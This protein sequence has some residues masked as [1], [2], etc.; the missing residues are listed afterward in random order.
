M[1]VKGAPES[2]LVYPDDIGIDIYLGIYK[3]ELSL[4]WFLHDVIAHARKVD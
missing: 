3:W 4:I 2:L 1:L